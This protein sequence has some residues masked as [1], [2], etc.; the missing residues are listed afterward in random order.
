MIIALLMIVAL[1]KLF[2]DVI[3]L[4]LHIVHHPS[5]HTHF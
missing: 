1:F 3:P 2:F 5:K 4:V